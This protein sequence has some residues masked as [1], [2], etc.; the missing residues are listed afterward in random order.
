MDRST[1]REVIE[2]YEKGEKTRDILMRTGIKSMATLYSI[3]KR[4][5][6]KKRPSKD[7]TKVAVSLDKDIQ[8]LIRRERPDNLSEWICKRIKES[9]K[10]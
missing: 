1:E 2:L 7:V 6:V 3:L 9:Y 4:N 8:Y 5:G 10:K